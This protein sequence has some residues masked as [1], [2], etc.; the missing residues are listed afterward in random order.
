MKAFPFRIL[1]PS[2]TYF[3]GE[4]I[5]L[6]FPTEEGSIGFLSGRADCVLSVSTGVFHYTLPSGETVR[7]A[8][9]GG[10]AE[11]KEGVFT[12]CTERAYP[13]ED[14]EK[15]HLEKEEE[16]EA[17]SRRQ[18]KIREEYTMYKVAMAKA[19]DKLKRSRHNNK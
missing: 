8:S 9:E 18:G 12:Y 5:S 16:R 2:E 4:V 7:L 19:F 13:E 6:V 10:V 14:A 17:E 15:A 11:M 3:E 1:T